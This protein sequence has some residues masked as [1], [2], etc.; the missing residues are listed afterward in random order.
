MRNSIILFLFISTGV[1]AQVDSFPYF[2]NH[3]NDISCITFSPDGKYII[4]GSWDN[5]AIIHK[6]D[7]TAETLEVIEG[8]R[9]AVT[10][11]A[12][13]RDG[14]SLII[15][16]QDGKLTFYEFND[17]FFQI[18]TEDTTYLLENTQINKLIYGPGMRTVF[19][20]C[21]DG[22]FITFDLVKKKIIPINGTTSIN[23]A[24]V[25]IDR[26]SYFI[27]VK[28]SP[29][30]TQ[31]DIFGK[32]LNTFEGHS[33]DITDLL[34]TVDRKF[35]ISSSKDKTIRVWDILNVKEDVVFTEHTWS[36]TDIDIDPLGLY[37]VS[38]GL[39]GTVNLYDLKEKKRL[40]QYTLE[41]YKI[42][43]LALSPDNTKI[44]AAAQPDSI[45]SPGGFF[46]IKTGI[47]ARKIV[48]P[49]K[50]DLQALRETNKR[51]ALKKKKQEKASENSDAE[52]NKTETS[53]TPKNKVELLTKT[54][55]ITITIKDNE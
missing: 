18:A 54:E 37:L 27:A 4:T 6:N 3:S 40:A 26:M 38:G 39:D 34:V 32:V 17:S 14:H 36:V 7:S 15:G 2:S 43:A 1:F 19:S 29:I 45:S 9:G 22:R 28:G 53:S 8:F 48:L 55:Q 41:G 11:M 16:G 10:T 5:T 20:A 49:K 35:L 21:N 25:A 12:F 30:I 24:A 42:N 13:S 23:A 51:R 33:N 31:F 46:A 44:V 50:M 47:P 52:N